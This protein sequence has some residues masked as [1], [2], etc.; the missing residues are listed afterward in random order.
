M[1]N[2]YPKE[3]VF[4]FQKSPNEDVWFALAERKGKLYLDLRVY[5]TQEDGSKIQTHKGIFLPV[6]KLEELKH[7]VDLTIDA[8]GRREG[9]REE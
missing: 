5:H 8:V 6:E 7:G 2:Y 9:S 1:F 3:K 4:S